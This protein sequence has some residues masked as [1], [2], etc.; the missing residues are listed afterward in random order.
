[1]FD[2][3]KRIYGKAQHGNLVLSGLLKCSVCD[4]THHFSRTN[5][6]IWIRKCST[7]DPFGN[8]CNNNN[9]GIKASKVTYAIIQHLKLRRVQLL[10][11][12]ENERKK[13]HKIESKI[14]KVQNEI[15]KL[16]K[17]LDR[18][19]ELYE[20]GEIDRKTYTQRNNE[21]KGQL[22]KLQAELLKLQEETHIS[23][24]DDSTNKVEL[25]DE[26]L[27]LVAKHGEDL[28]EA[29]L[30]EDEISTL[31]KLLRQLIHHVVYHREGKDINLGINYN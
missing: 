6:G 22:A 4:S 28:D 11:P 23:K 14:N 30:S 13:E 20:F 21:R 26:L 31:N 29:N 5:K 17:A 3:R 16:N 25:I 15:N 24:V 2:S 18:L 19:L 10:Q 8:K 7:P 12:L 9:K 27:K 1:M